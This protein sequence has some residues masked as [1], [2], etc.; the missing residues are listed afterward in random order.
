[1]SHHAIDIFKDLC[2]FEGRMLLVAREKDKKSPAEKLFF[3]VN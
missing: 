1:M 2:I 3:C